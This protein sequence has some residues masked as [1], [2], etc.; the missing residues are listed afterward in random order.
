[1]WTRPLIAQ[2]VATFDVMMA[3]VSAGLALGLAGS[4]CAS[5]RDPGV[6]ARCLTGKPPML[7]TYLLRRDVEP[8]EMLTRFIARV[9]FIDSADDSAPSQ[10]PDPPDERTG[11][12]K[13]VMLLALV[14]VLTACVPTQP[15]ETVEA[16]IANPKRIKEIQ[17]QYEKT[18]Q[19]SVTNSAV[20]LPKPPIDVSSV[21]SR[22]SFQIDHNTLA[23]LRRTSRC[24]PT[25]P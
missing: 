17:Q 19:R 13:K 7:T 12:M 2:H 18:A 24:Y 8:S 9:A 22:S 23:S 3:L 14:T 5:N 16:L 1:M 4:A 15:S 20:A 6:V 10:I 21:I 25:T 11:T